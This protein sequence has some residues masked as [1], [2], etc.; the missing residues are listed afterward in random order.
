MKRSRLSGAPAPPYVVGV[1][2]VSFD[3]N[4][5]EIFCIIGLS[6]SGKS[7]LLRHINGLIRPTAGEVIINGVSIKELSD[8]RLLQ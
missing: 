4:E 7:T 8:A 6:G 2:D 3:I 1:E 5:G